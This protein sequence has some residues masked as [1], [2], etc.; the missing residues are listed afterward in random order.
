MT[1]IAAQGVAVSSLAS[2]N[3]TTAYA[4][5][6]GATISVLS[7]LAGDLLVVDG[8]VQVANIGTTDTCFARV[9]ATDPTDT[10]V[11]T[12]T[13]YPQTSPSN[14]SVLGLWTVVTPGTVVVRVQHKRGAAGTSRASAASLRVLHYRP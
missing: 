9:A 1:L 4:D 12:E 11:G 7:C 3:T 8:N 14:Q 2:D 13:Q 6:P 5:V 10:L